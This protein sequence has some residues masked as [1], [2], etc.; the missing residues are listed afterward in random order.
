MEIRKS[1]Q[2]GDGGNRIRAAVLAAVLV[3][4]GGLQGCAALVGAGAGAAGGIAYTQRGVK[5]EVKGEVSQV[6][7]DAEAVFKDLGI[8]RTGSEMKRSGEEQRLT[9]QRGSTEVNVVIRRSGNEVS[10]V[11]V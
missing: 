7:K 9:G 11:E 1:M 5:G 2:S 8:R 10:T 6:R 3:M 4:A